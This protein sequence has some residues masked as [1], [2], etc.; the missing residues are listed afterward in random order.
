MKLNLKELFDSTVTELNSFI[1][2]D[3]SEEVKFFFREKFNISQYELLMNKTTLNYLEMNNSIDD[4]IKRR[5]KREPVQYIIGH[6]WFYTKKIFV[7]KDVLIPR[8]ETELLVAETIKI[9][10]KN[11]IDSVLEIGCG[12]GAIGVELLDHCSTINYT[13]TDISELAIKLT[14]KNI[15]Y[16]KLSS[17]AHILKDDLYTG[18]KNFSLIVSNPPYINKEDMKKLE[19]ELSFEPETA[20]Y[21]GDDGLDYYRNIIII[22]KNILQN[23]GYLIFEIGY[24][25]KNEIIEF[26]ENINLKTIKTLKDYSGHD[27]IIIFRRDYE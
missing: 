18:E 12:S 23:K 7:E 4:Y 19:E 21:G 9:I 20:L 2:F 3:T 16:Y 26:A 27:R 10:N 17:R 25:Q 24:D 1:P 11:N 6:S 15:E 14:K 5:K 13:G 22:S 8:P